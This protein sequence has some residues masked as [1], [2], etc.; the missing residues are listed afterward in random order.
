MATELCNFSTL[1]HKFFSFL[2][3]DEIIIYDLNGVLMAISSFCPHFGGP[4]VV[5]G[6]KINC[7]WHDWSFDISNHF[8]INKKVN[9]R[10]KS[11]SIERLSENQALITYDN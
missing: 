1:P 9:L 6:H 8:C 4:L 7:Y 2:I 11:Y 3:N 10:L 5:T